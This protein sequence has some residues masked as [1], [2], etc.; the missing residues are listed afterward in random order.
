[1]NTAEYVDP[2]A[3]E[4]TQ[5]FNRCYPEKTVYVRSTKKNGEWLHKVL[6]N[7]DAG[8]RHLKDDDLRFAIRG[9]N[10]EIGRAHV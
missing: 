1:M 4:Y 9:F 6:I 3:T 5:S 10:R 2:L 7:G 8:E